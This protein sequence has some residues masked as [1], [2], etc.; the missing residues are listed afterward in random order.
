LLRFILKKHVFNS[1]QAQCCAHT[2]KKSESFYMTDHAFYRTYIVWKGLWSLYFLSIVLKCFSDNS[3]SS[4]G[5][6][7]QTEI[8]QNI[9]GAQSQFF[10]CSLNV[11]I[12][13]LLIPV[14]NQC[15][16]CLCIWVFMII[17]KFNI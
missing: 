15:D 5:Y 1:L 14:I 7:H 2:K 10:V 13:G 12:V 17:S 11:E 8:W 9:I 3:L 16:A 4:N 6:I